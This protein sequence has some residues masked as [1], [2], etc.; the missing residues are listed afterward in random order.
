MQGIQQLGAV[1]CGCGVKLEAWRLGKATEGSKVQTHTS[2]GERVV[3]ILKPSAAG[4][5]WV[6][7]EQAKWRTVTEGQSQ[8]PNWP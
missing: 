8:R 3:L 1:Q 2:A 4:V 7:G 5:T 6:G